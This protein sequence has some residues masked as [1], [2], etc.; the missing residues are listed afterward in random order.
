MA[1]RRREIGSQVPSRDL[2]RWPPQ[3]LPRGRRGVARGTVN[4]RRFDGDRRL[5]GEPLRLGAQVERCASREQEPAQHRAERF[6]GDGGAGEGGNFSCRGVGLLSGE[7]SLLERERGDVAGGIYMLDAGDAPDLSTGMKPCWSCGSPGSLGPSK[8][9]RVTT[10]SAN[11]SAPPA[12]KSMRPRVI[13][14]SDEVRTMMP[15]ASS[16]ERTAS[17]AA[18]RA[19][20]PRG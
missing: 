12:S 10:R 3:R 2:R 1:P 6:G 9:G 17:V 11:T 18:A 14:G 4:R 16:S 15:L 5:A 13:A 20:L 19:A 7:S 8:T